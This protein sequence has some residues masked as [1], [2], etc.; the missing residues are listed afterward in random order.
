MRHV[1][2]QAALSNSPM[3]EQAVTSPGTSV[4]LVSLSE[5]IY[6]IMRQH[7]QS[8]ITKSF[9]L[10]MKLKFIKD[11]ICFALEFNDKDMS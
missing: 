4:G 9:F 6:K 3:A 10:K 2:L 8:T 1:G 5:V 11:N 7:T